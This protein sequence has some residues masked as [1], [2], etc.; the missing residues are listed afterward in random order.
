MQ[1][2]GALSK[3][4]LTILDLLGQ[5]V[6]SGLLDAQLTSLVGHLAPECL[7]DLMTTTTTA[8]RVGAATAP[9]RGVATVVDEGCMRRPLPAI[10]RPTGSIRQVGYM[11]RFQCVNV[12][13]L[14]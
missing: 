13:H 11:D 3:A 7:E 10:K 6:N 9:A 1:S 14:R 12:S 2:N 5:V 4:L 8:G